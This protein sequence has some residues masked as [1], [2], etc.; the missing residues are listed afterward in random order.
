MAAYK[1]LQRGVQQGTIG[2]W[3]FL[4]CL[5]KIYH[6]QVHWLYSHCAGRKR[7]LPSREWEESNCKI[8]ITCTGSGSVSLIA[9]LQGF[10]TR[11]AWL[12]RGD[13]GWTNLCRHILILL[14]PWE[15][16]LAQ[17][18]ASQCFQCSHNSNR[19]SL[20]WKIR[21]TEIFCIIVMETMKHLPSLVIK[22]CSMC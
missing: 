15:T 3:W 7:L 11:A 2:A 17:A 4:L 22:T 21:L 13:A 9:R 5:Y 14:P 8:K 12:F 16:V 20:T 1:L 18:A 10:C 19:T 6:G